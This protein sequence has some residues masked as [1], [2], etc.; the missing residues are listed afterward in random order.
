MDRENSLFK[1]QL[2]TAEWAN[3]KEINTYIAVVVNLP[4]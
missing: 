2:A 4:E 3:A 1:E